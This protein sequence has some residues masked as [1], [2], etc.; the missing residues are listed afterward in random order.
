[1]K[2]F[3]ICLRI[4]GESYELAK[5]IANEG[6]VSMWIRGLIRQEIEKV[7]KEGKLS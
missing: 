6:N 1:M 5:K 4:D 7:K 2:N 3:N